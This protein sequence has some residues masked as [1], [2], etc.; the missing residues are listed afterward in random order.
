MIE[1]AGGKSLGKL[2]G[3]KE[4]NAR[5]QLEHAERIGLGTRKYKLVEI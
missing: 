2:T 4:L 5:S 3:R 1:Q